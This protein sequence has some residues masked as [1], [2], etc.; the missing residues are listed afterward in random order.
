MEEERLQTS[1]SPSVHVLQIVE[2]VGRMLALE[3]SYERP[4]RE[5]VR[6][7]KDILAPHLEETASGQAQISHLIALLND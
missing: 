3:H 1:R 7:Y 5:A 6:G 2:G 4:V